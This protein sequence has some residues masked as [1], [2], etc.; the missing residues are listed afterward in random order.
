MNKMDE[1]QFSLDFVSPYWGWGPAG[2][3]RPYFETHGLK[4]ILG[5]F[6]I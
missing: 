1:I 6:Q 5:Q 2:P 3:Q 4:L